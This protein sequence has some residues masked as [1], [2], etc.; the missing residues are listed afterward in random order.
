M[1]GRGDSPVDDHEF[2]AAWVDPHLGWLHR[3]DGLS[4]PQREAV[5]VW[6]LEVEVSNGG[7][8]QYFGN[9]RGAWAAAA[10]DGLLRIGATAT[11]AMLRRA[12]AAVGPLPLPED[13]GE[14]FDLLDR[15]AAAAGFAAME[16]EFH[17]G[18]EDRMALLAAQLRAA[19][20]G[21]T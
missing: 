19:A 17:A 3:P 12:I 13:R 15:A 1:S 10:V 20:P 16:D 14:R 7:L 5:A 4:T 9:S 6:L 18:T 2:V 11:A 8:H 21:V